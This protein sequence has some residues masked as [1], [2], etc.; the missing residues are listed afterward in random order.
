M[1]RPSTVAPQNYNTNRLVAYAN[2]I[3]DITHRIKISAGLSFVDG[4]MTF[5]VNNWHVDNKSVSWRVG[6]I[7]QVTDH[8]FAFADYTT[9]YVPQNPGGSFGAGT[10]TYY[11]PLTGNQME[12]GYK[13]VVGDKADQREVK[14]GTEDDVEL[15]EPGE[16]SA[17]AF[18]PSK[19]PLH[20]IALLV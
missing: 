17:E 2:D 15:L 19:Q 7:V 4:Q 9:A 14:E 18:E 5:L 6:P 11:S 12:A 10:L 3:A 16:D 20:L 13:H 8:G 1:T